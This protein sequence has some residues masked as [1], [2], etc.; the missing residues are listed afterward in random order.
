[1]TLRFL[2]GNRVF[3]VQGCLFKVIYSICLIFLNKH[4]FNSYSIFSE[5]VLWPNSKSLVCHIFI[6]HF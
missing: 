6:V 4:L 5:L 1:M 2:R 3:Q